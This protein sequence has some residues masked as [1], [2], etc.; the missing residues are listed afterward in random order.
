MQH[1]HLLA[2]AFAIATV[3]VC[4]PAWA[5]GFDELPDQGAEALGRGAA[6]TAK[7]D[8]ATALH[9]NV[10]G[11]AGQRGTKLQV[12]GNLQ[13]SQISFARSG[14]YPDSPTNPATPWGGK[15]FPVVTNAQSA[16]LLPMIVATT[17]FGVFERLTF[18]VGFWG[19]S[20]SIKT[21][22]V[23]THGQPSP[24]RYDAV[25]SSGIIGLPTIGA[26]LRLT[27]NIDIGLSGQLVVAHLN[28]LSIGYYDPGG[29]A[30][31][32]AEYSGCDVPT[33]LD[34][35][36]VAPAAAVGI[37]GRPATGVQ[38]GAQVRT[39]ASVDVSGTATTKV[40]S[41]ILPPS[42]ASFSLY[43][44]WVV[45]AGARYASMERDF[46]RYDV[47]IDA[48]YETW[49]MGPSG[50]TASTSNPMT[51][52]PMNITI[53]HEWKNTFSLRAGGAYN[54]PLS[55]GTLTLRGGAFY[56]SPTTDSAYTRVDF[57]TLPKVAGTLGVGYRTKRYGVNFAYA[58][59]G[60]VSRVVTDGAIQPMN[61]AKGGAPVS[62]DG[63][64]LAA[65][66]NGM[67]TA[68][69]HVLSLGV[70]IHFFGS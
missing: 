20:G 23:Y 47:E 44:P 32:N 58:A 59:V 11:L 62:G 10:A 12:S 2:V 24:A 8:D 68:L 48:T 29:G 18:G 50:L 40:G 55:D 63:A 70:E 41:T 19:P 28:T 14:V 5:G 45:R 25:Q 17:D 66:N 37:L 38:L 21:F 51:K 42:P 3:V 13:F 61:A 27:P 22:P 34:V 39:P 54:I 49:G 52:E 65:V 33:R 64:P 1:H 57:N 43:F 35:S 15:S 53:V 67:Y 60:S 36:G 46:E 69:A 30:C 56:D 9:Y 26:G 6:F 16:F 4:P 31:K 7:A